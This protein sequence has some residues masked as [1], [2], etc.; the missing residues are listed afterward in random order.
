LLRRAAPLRTR[1]ACERRHVDAGD[2]WRRDRESRRD[3]SNSN[4]SFIPGA[5][6]PIA[7]AVDSN[8]LYGFNQGTN[9]IGR[10]NLDRS[11]P[12]PEFH[13]WRDEPLR[14]RVPSRVR[15]EAVVADTLSTA[16]GNVDAFGGERL[17]D[18]EHGCS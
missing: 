7:I 11:N 4:L 16:E 17:R 14:H 18:E 15:A 8:Y 12:E 13:H 6:Q 3:G 10:A 5:S 1:P 2:C 9:A